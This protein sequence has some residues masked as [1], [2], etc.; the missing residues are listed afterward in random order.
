MRDRDF[1]GLLGIICEVTSEPIL[2]KKNSP[3]ASE[4]TIHTK[5]FP[6]DT[7]EVFC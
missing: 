6:N 5:K 1:Q 7:F 4:N 2:I 3:K